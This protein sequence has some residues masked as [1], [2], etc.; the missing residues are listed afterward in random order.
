MIKRG[1]I[2]SS[3]IVF[4]ICFSLIEMS[5]RLISATASDSSFLVQDY[6]YMERRELLK[7]I[8][9]YLKEKYGTAEDI[10][11]YAGTHWGNLAGGDVTV[12]LI[13]TAEKSPGELYFIY[14]IT[15]N[16]SPAVIFHAY[17]SSSG[18]VHLGPIT[19]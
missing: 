4:F 7:K 2:L 6:K 10:I 14:R 3:V 1:F 18:E 9:E 17:S 11:K 12:I 19:L 8:S 5:G 13:S 16:T 15:I